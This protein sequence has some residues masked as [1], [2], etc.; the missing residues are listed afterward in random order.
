MLEFAHLSK[1]TTNPH[2]VREPVPLALANAFGKA[3][4]TRVR[5]L[6]N[7]CPLHSTTPLHRLH[8]LAGA[9]DL[10]CVF[11]KDEGARLGLGSFKALGGV[12]A[13]AELVL[14][15]ATE[16][17]YRDVAPHELTSPA[18]KAA[19]SAQTVCCATDG[20]HGRSVAAGARL[21]GCQ[22]VIFVHQH[23]AE[24]QRGALRALDARVIE[25]AGTY[26]DSVDECA[27]AASA[28]NWHVV[29]D[30]SWN[31][32]GAVP[33][34]VMQGYSV[35]IDEALSQMD[36]PPTHV[37]VQGGVGGLA[38]AIAA[39]LADRFEA[40][41]PMLVVVEPDRAACLMASILAGA[42]TEITAGQSTVMAM[43]ECYR[44]SQT[45]WP[46]L[47]SYADAFLTV[48]ENAAPDI[49]MLLANPMGTDPAISAGLSGGVGLAGLI[50]AAQEPEV[51]NGLSL[52]QN[53]RVLT[54]ITE[55]PAPSQPTN[56]VKL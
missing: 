55:G 54:I 6:L 27:R 47:D 5:R 30:T 39:R 15:W 19:V 25:V 1:F 45:A 9:L 14:D 46:I 3:A 8:A 18:V 21:F 20:N 2:A 26:D 38:G 22:A 40:S 33:R 52:D 28:N 13:V 31:S 49:V 42:A 56:G 51:R 34:R 41:R 16:R 48:P 11:A 44:P 23:V 10:G 53:S 35:L 4:L 36:E 50:A 37:F 24:E 17:L 7:L 29:S 32:D 12:Y 43:L